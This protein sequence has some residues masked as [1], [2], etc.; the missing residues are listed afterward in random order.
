MILYSIIK[1]S[2]LISKNQKQE[3]TKETG[4][5]KFKFIQNFTVAIFT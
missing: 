4:N 2:E 5:Y 1:V 3:E